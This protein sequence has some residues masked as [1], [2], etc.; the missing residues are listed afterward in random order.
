[1]KKLLF[2]LLAAIAVSVASA[3]QTYNDFD[4]DYYCQTHER[5][6]EYQFGFQYGT[7]G[8]RCSAIGRAQYRFENVSN[9]YLVRHNIFWLRRNWIIQFNTT[10]DGIK[11]W[12]DR[13]YKYEYRKTIHQII[14]G[15]CYHN[16]QWRWV[17]FSGYSHTKSHQASYYNYV[18]SR[19]DDEFS[20]P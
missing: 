18:K 2:L 15:W 3:N 17:C 20:T 16:L 10:E 19:V 7:N 13:Y 12:V 4:I 14:F 1:M 9:P 6:D 11:F 5:A 8:E